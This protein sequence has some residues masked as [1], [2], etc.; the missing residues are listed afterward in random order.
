L[1]I[2]KGAAAWISLPIILTAALAA[3]GSW[4]AS[5]LALMGTLFVIFFHRDPDRSPHGDGM[6]SPAD[7]RVVMAGSDRI[8]I[9]MGPYD[10]HVNRSPMD[11]L[12]KSTVY[13]KGGHY[14]AFLG[15]ASKNQQNRIKIETAEGEIEISQIA[16]A[17]ARRIVCYVN[18][19]DKVVRGQRI[20]MIHFGSRVEV[21]IPKGYRNFVELGD[22]VRAGESI[23]A[24]KSA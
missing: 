9:F 7:G 21:T 24:V 3:I 15:I 5:S 11:G 20:G 12:V 19:G 18:P 2:A 6:I 4:Y 23:I 17:I 1:K 13:S 10:V 14:P 8:A 16:G 22:K